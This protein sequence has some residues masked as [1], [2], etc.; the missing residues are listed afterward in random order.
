MEKHFSAQLST[1]NRMELLSGDELISRVRW[2]DSDSI[3]IKEKRWNSQQNRDAQG[4]QELWPLT[5]MSFENISLR[6]GGWWCFYQ[7]QKS[8]LKIIYFAS[9]S[10]I[11]LGSFTSPHFIL[12]WDSFHQVG[13]KIYFIDNLEMFFEQ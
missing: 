4:T 12:L 13:I 9:V 2:K 8:T 3:G 10:V 1:Q 5:E 6:W 11:P 7:M